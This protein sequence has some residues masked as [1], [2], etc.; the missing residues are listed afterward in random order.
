MVKKIGV[1]LCLTVYILLDLLSLGSA[2]ADNGWGGKLHGHF[3]ASCVRN[4]HTKNY[5]NL[6]TG[7]QVIIEMSGMFFGTQCRTLKMARGLE[8]NVLP[9]AKSFYW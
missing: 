7:F 1:F 6:V 3:M 9:K 5:Q 4:I 8:D 2:D